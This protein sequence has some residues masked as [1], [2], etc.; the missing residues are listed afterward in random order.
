MK[1]VLCHIIILLTC[2]LAMSQGQ[3]TYAL[4][5]N[6]TSSDTIQP[7]DPVLLQLTVFNSVAES[8]KYHNQ[9]VTQ[10]LTILESDYAKGA[11]DEEEYQST[12][13]LLDSAFLKVVSVAIPGALRTGK[14]SFFLDSLKIRARDVLNCYST[15]FE[16][17]DSVKAGDRLL[18]TF[19]IPQQVTTKWK[20]GQHHVIARIDTID[21]QKASLL[22]TRGTNVG[23]SEER[24]LELGYFYLECLQILKAETVADALLKTHPNSINVTILKAEIL[25]AQDEEETATSWF[26]KAL[27]LFYEKYPD[28][29][30]PPEYL[31][32]RISEIKPDGRN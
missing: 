8:A 29:Y 28:S 5:V 30:E 18:L 11:I 14:I 25:L 7:G 26:E 16:T 6:H 2:N 9:I 23:R 4:L 3:L 32:D 13:K 21:S 10:N 17:T 12:K 19:G 24:Q 20:L 27:D 31:L 15:D 22:V 1:S